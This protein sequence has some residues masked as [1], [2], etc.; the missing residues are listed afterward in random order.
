M[1]S[2]PYY[3][4]VYKKQK[5]SVLYPVRDVILYEEYTPYPEGYELDVVYNICRI[6]SKLLR[7][8]IVENNPQNQAFSGK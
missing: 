4:V 6:Y 7:Q 1:Y 5:T 8:A 2:I 3:N